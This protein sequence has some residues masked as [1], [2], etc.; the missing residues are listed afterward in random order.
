MWFFGLKESL[1]KFMM[2]MMMMSSSSSSYSIK[3]SSS[4]SISLEHP[5][6]PIL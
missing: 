6:C 5:V 4:G 1:A 2:M 3:N